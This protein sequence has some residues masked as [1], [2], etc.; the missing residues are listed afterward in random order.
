MN[1]PKA[2]NAKLEAA[3]FLP[4]KNPYK[5]CALSGRI[6]GVHPALKIFMHCKSDG[7]IQLPR[8]AQSC[9]ELYSDMQ[10]SS[11]LK[12]CFLRSVSLIHT[13]QHLMQNS[14]N[15]NFSQSKNRIM[16]GPGVLDWNVIELENEREKVQC[17]WN[18]PILGN[19]EDRKATIRNLTRKKQREDMSHA[20]LD[21]LFL[22]LFPLFF[23]IF[24][25]IYWVSFLYV[26]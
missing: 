12:M 22:L 10:H 25:V 26:G 15:A 23:L 16:R 17:R 1:P 20:R 5:Q 21:I 14:L 4:S 8:P 9:S 6:L 19:L 2:W 7:P 11:L 13:F 24:N 3:S 18:P